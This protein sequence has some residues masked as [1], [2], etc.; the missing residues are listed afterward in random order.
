MENIPFRYAFFLYAAYMCFSAKVFSACFYS[1]YAI[2]LI[3]F[4]YLFIHAIIPDR[5]RSG[6]LILTLILARY[7]NHLRWVHTEIL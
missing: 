6:M 5:F 3:F 4:V 1:L 2:F 7:P